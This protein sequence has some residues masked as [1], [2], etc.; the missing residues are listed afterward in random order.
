M[1]QH[2]VVI[3]DFSS[4][5]R[6][7]MPQPGKREKDTE[8]Q[9]QNPF[10]SLLKAVS[11][12]GKSSGQFIKT[13]IDRIFSLPRVWNYSLSHRHPAKVFF[14]SWCHWGCSSV[15]RASD[16]HAADAGSIPRCGKGFFSRS[17]LSDSYGF[18]T[19]AVAC[20]NICANV[21]NLVVHARVRWIIETLKHPACNVGWIARLSRSWLSPG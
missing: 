21:K 2:E 13:D 14:F 9:S 11:E 15:D 17:Q 16:R 8:N 18:R 6:P 1:L 3:M 5:G 7:A 19:C 10:C 4:W 12:Q 20:I